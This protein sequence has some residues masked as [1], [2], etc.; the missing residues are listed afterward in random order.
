MSR[1]GGLAGSRA[2]RAG[3]LREA[4]EQDQHCGAGMPQPGEAVGAAGRVA[5]RGQRRCGAGGPAQQSA[6]GPH[7][8]GGKEGPK[9]RGTCVT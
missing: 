9:P 7:Q 3:E 2:Q 5:A 8:A 4:V 6:A 1:F